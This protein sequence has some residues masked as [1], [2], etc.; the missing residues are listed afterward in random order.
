MKTTTTTIH[1]LTHPRSRLQP[2]IRCPC[3]HCLRRFHRLRWLLCSALAPRATL[4]VGRYIVV[5][6]RYPLRPPRAAAA[7]A[8]AAVLLLQ[9]PRSLLLPVL[10]DLVKLPPRGV[11]RFRCRAS[12]FTIRPYV[13]PPLPPPPP[14]PTLTSVPPAT[15]S[16]PIVG[17]KPGLC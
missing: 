12:R 4:I 15:S 7:A 13:P 1:A 17:T 16:R 14:T 9:P 10:T 2:C 11:R 5:N 8:A 6:L 3:R